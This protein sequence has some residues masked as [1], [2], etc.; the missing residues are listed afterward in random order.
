ML[1]TRGMKL[2]RAAGH[3]CVAAIGNFDGVHLGHQAILSVLANRSREAGLPAAVLTFEP[4]PRE[5]FAPREAPARLMRLRDKVEALAAMGVGRLHVLRFDAVLSSWDGPTFIDRILGRALGAKRVVIG[6]GFRYGRDRRGD[7]ALLRSEG[8]HLG[9][10]V[11]EVPRYEIGGLRVSSTRLREALAAGRLD[12]ARSLLGR[13]YR[14]SGRVVAGDRLGRRLG[15]PTAN[16]RLQRRASPLAGVFAVRVSGA[17]L[18]RQSGVASVGTRPTV[19]GGEWLLEV[20]LF[21]FDGELYRRRLAVD[22]VARLRDEVHYPDLP[23]MT[24]Q[25]HEDARAARRL[26]GAGG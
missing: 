23:T 15:Y 22:F 10:E 3:A 2:A 16:I 11:D 4:H 9:F 6:E 21:D 13:D 12:E 5:Y 17:G 1:I 25:M 26:L 24:A 7:V 14:I 20:H 19:G 8:M 18:S